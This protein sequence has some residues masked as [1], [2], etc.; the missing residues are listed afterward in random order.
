MY[1]KITIKDS[2]TGISEKDLPHIFE[3]FYKGENSE[4]GSIGIGLALAKAI[5]QKENGYISVTSKQG[6][7]TE[8]VIK[9]M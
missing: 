2:D 3:R 6:V 7:G 5:I 1:T 9:Y 8:F 4:N